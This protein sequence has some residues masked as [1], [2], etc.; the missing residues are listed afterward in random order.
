MVSASEYAILANAAYAGD[1]NQAALRSIET[2]SN[3]RYSR[4]SYEV[5]D[6]DADYK[7]FKKKATN[8]II[9]ACRGTSGID[10]VLP[11]I[12]TAVGMLT[13]SPRS[14]K[15]N[16]VV[17]EYSHNN[18]NVTVTG[19]SLGGKLAAIAAAS[20]DVLGVTFNQGSSPIDYFTHSIGLEGKYRY[21]NIIHFT[22][23]KDIVS[24]SACLA[25]DENTIQVDSPSNVDILDNHR[26]S[27]YFDLDDT[28][29]QSILD[30]KAAGITQ[31]RPLTYRSPIDEV[32]DEE[33]AM[34]LDR[35]YYD[36]RALMKTISKRLGAMEL[37]RRLTGHF[38]AKWDETL[39][40]YKSIKKLRQAGE[41]INLNDVRQIH[42]RAAMLWSYTP[43]EAEAWD[44][45]LKDGDV[46][47]DI[48]NEIEHDE[49]VNQIQPDESWEGSAWE[50]DSWEPSEDPFEPHQISVDD[51]KGL[52]LPADDPIAPRLPDD[53]IAPNLIDGEVI[54]DAT[55]AEIKEISDRI[56][57]GIK[58]G[59][60]I[61]A[62]K[63]RM[64]IRMREMGIPEEI[65]SQM[66]REVESMFQSMS[67][68]K[69]L[70]E[71]GMPT[72][73][74]GVAGLYA[75][76]GALQST[77]TESAVNAARGIYSGIGR[78]Y[79][80]GKLI[81]TV[82]NIGS[83]VA[84]SART[85]WTTDS[86]VIKTLTGG[87]VLV[88]TSTLFKALVDTIGWAAQIGFLIGDVVKVRQE[89]IHIN[90]LKARLKNGDATTAKLRWK[91]LRGIEFAEYIRGYDAT[92]AGVHGAELFVAILTTV[93]APEAAP[94][95]WGGIAAEQLSELGIDPLYIEQYQKWYRTRYYGD[96][97]RPFNYYHMRDLEEGRPAKLQVSYNLRFDLVTAAKNQWYG[98][99]PFKGSN[100]EAVVKAMF[101]LEATAD[102]IKKE[103]NTMMGLADLTYEKLSAFYKQHSPQIFLE[104]LAYIAKDPYLFGDLVRSGT[105][106][107]S[108]EV[109]TSLGRLNITHRG[110]SLEDRIHADQLRNQLINERNREKSVWKSHEQRFLDNGNKPQ[111]DHETD[112]EYNDRVERWIN[113]QTIKEE[114]EAA[115][116]E[117][118]SWFPLPSDIPGATTVTPDGAVCTR[119]PRKRRRTPVVTSMA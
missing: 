57:L 9:I 27:H 30:K 94:F 10:D 91:L 81:S 72:L 11:D 110:A 93:L 40:L 56:T 73:G 99:G 105:D 33:Y 50:D 77:V 12:M 58:N 46:T 28:K 65:I 49:L 14:I 1:D 75:S 112:E 15:I 67:L 48:F 43:E 66:G 24:T 90:E 74:K 83:G 119:I 47:A 20:E 92:K 63:T 115:I 70:T 102:A 3:G 36:I 38:Q 8:E 96:P 18:R 4:D 2:E 60:G 88:A 32:D 114:Q 118:S 64:T 34:I 5:L 106:M 19:H 25:D 45:F 113:D 71:L 21:D 68:S 108:Y 80:G 13:L 104:G 29:Y 95:V 86:I 98:Y 26:I 52:G 89:D 42:Q 79:V 107:T 76:M 82:K 35:T 100:W 84:K 7:V 31:R 53:D 111:G 22:N 59:L 61:N 55:E 23:C 116:D 103:S 69:L 6:G 101:K 41:V 54:R 85:F 97:P 39:R 17:R 62:I 44:A 109:Y 51:G 117:A 16:K 37:N 78:T 87:K